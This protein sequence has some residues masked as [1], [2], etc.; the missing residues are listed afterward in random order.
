MKE[1]HKE[2]T[3]KTETEQEENYE[4][5]KELDSEAVMEYLSEHLNSN[6]EED[7]ASRYYWTIMHALLTLV[8]GG[9]WVFALMA[10]W[11]Y[12]FKNKM[13]RSDRKFTKDYKVLEVEE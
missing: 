10:Y 1:E 8:T 5:R 2:R 13:D 11:V 3:E 4:V 9:V 6:T 12:K 7:Y